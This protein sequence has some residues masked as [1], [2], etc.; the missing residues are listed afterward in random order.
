MRAPDEI[1][2]RHGRARLLFDPQE[3]IQ[4]QTRHPVGHVMPKNPYHRAVSMSALLTGNGKVSINFTVCRHV[5][6]HALHELEHARFRQRLAHAVFD[7][8]L[9]N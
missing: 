2:C 7:R 1:R 6:W 4:R 9:C 3:I 5:R 8:R